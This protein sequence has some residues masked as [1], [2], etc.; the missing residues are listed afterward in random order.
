MGGLKVFRL[1][2]KLGPIHGAAGVAGLRLLVIPNRDQEYF[3]AKL[4][5]LAPGQ[6]AERVKPEEIAAGR[7]LIKYLSGRKPG[8]PP[9]LDLNGMSPFSR[10]VL[11][12][13]LKIPYGR[14]L[15]YGEVAAKV[16]EPQAARA[17]GRA[18]GSNPM[19]IVIPCHR[20]LGKGGALTGYGSGLDTKRSLLALERGDLVLT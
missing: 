7:W 9:A 17:V 5:E 14:S 6:K 19:P 15:S 16:G 11:T 12:E 3:E 4:A 8:R 13:L 10:A 1:N 18:V 20:V 2:S